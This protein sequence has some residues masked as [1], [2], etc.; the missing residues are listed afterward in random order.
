MKFSL[1]TNI[2]N[3]QY[4]DFHYIVTENARR[5]LG[6]ILSDYHTGI[7]CFT[8]VGTYGT[9]KSIFLAALERDFLH[10]TNVLFENRGQ[11]SNYT[12]FKCINV[13]GDYTSLSNLLSEQLER[14]NVNPKELFAQLEH[15]LINHRK[16]NEFVVLVID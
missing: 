8:L 11:F 15:K 10:N 5:V 13:I 1:S 6:T 9:G 16:N 4:D 14:D 7:H 12:K 2:K 3:V